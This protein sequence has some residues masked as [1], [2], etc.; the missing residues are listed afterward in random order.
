MASSGASRPAPGTSTGAPAVVTPSERVGDDEPRRTWALV[1]FMMS[2]IGGLVAYVPEPWGWIFAG[3]G[4][5]ML[6][7]SAVLLRSTRDKD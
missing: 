5:C 7:A 6:A 1:L 4:A 3:V 2:G